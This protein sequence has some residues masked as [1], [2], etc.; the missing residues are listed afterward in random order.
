MVVLYSMSLPRFW[1]TS[2]AALSEV[3]RLKV[4]SVMTWGFVSLNVG[5]D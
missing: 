4:C 1:G 3:E 2:S 5:V